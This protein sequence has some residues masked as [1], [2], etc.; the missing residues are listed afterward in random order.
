MFVAGTSGS[1]A[2]YVNTGLTYDAVT[3]AITGA[4]A[5]GTF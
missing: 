2:H 1:Q 3:N 4:I 5:G